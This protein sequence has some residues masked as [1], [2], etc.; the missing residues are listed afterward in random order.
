MFAKTKT[1]RRCPGSK[2]AGEGML[3]LGQKRARFYSGLLVWSC[4]GIQPLREMLTVYRLP[5]EETISVM[6]GHK[7]P[8]GP[9]KETNDERMSEI[10]AYLMIKRKRKFRMSFNLHC[11]DRF[12][13]LDHQGSLSPTRTCQMLCPTWILKITIL[14]KVMKP[15][16]RK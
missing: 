3:F 11:H 7:P 13:Y 9:S 14:K 4:K 5:F 10:I 8:G 16:L 6:S 15:V 12:F 1:A 2:P